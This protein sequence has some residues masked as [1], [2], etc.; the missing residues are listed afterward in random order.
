MYQ[1]GILAERN[2]PEWYQ[3]VRKNDTF[4]GLLWNA[5]SAQLGNFP[6]RYNLQGAASYV[7]GTHNIKFGYQYQWGVYPRYNTANAD[8]YQT[9]NN[10]VPFQVTVLNTPLEVREDLN[11]NLGFYAQDSWNLNRLTVNYGL[12]FDFNKQ[13]IQGQPAFFGRAENGEQH[14]DFHRAR[15]MEPPVVVVGEVPSALIVVDVNR[16]GL[17][18]TRVAEMLDLGVERGLVHHELARVVWAAISF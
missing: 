6:D 18:P 9:Y 15:R 14:G 5:S 4:T 7:T 2:T 16:D 8:L 3:N 17:E 10:S 11:A 1:P 12:R 13:T